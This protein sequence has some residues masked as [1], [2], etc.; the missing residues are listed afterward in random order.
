[1]T[2]LKNDLYR[3]LGLGFLLGALGV[4]LANPALAQAVTAL[5]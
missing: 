2:F 4:V 3:N 5:I 1:M